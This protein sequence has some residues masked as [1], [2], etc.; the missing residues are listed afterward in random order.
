MA[1]IKIA[2]DVLLQSAAYFR[3][4]SNHSGGIEL[5]WYPTYLR[6]EGHSKIVGKYKAYGNARKGALL[7]FIRLLVTTTKT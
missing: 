3:K 4:V 1:V 5:L 6:V 2:V 7:S